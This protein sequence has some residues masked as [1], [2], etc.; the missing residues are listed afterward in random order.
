MSKRI[1]WILH[2][3]FLLLAFAGLVVQSGWLFLI[4]IILEAIMLTYTIRQNRKK[5]GIK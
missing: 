5:R 1:Q 2:V 3:I 4:G